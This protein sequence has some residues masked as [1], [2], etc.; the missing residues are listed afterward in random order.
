MTARF[1]ERVS[2]QRTIPSA[3]LDIFWGIGLRNFRKPLKK[4]HIQIPKIKAPEH[5]VLLPG[6]LHLA[7]PRTQEKVWEKCKAQSP[8]VIPARCPHIFQEDEKVFI[9]MQHS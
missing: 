9:L 8:L 4:I 6:P 7:M 5:L 2:N 1:N 3:N